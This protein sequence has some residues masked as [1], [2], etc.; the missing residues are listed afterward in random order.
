[1]FFFLHSCFFLLHCLFVCFVLYLCDLVAL[2][3]HD[4]CHLRLSIVQRYLY[5]CF[6]LAHDIHGV[7]FPLFPFGPAV[8]MGTIL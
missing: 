4:Y 5:V 2:H 3:D 8:I 1:F 6:L 7:F